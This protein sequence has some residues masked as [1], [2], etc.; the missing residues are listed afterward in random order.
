MRD[1][2]DKPHKS[3]KEKNIKNEKILAKIYKLQQIKKYTQFN[4]HVLEL[5]EFD[6]RYYTDVTVNNGM[7]VYWNNHF[8]L[9]GIN[10]D[11]K[12]FITHFRKTLPFQNGTTN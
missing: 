5:D 11:K 10:S 3:L 4:F 6:V 7:N 2:K 9:Q 1:I 12:N 8:G